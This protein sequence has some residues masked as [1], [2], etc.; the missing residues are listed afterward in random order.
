MN[1]IPRNVHLAG[2]RPAASQKRPST[3]TL[4]DS[5]RDHG[6]WTRAA[7]LYRLHLRRK[8]LDFAI[9]VQLGHA[10]KEFGSHVEALQAY[11]K[12]FNINEN[13]LDLLL[14]L[15]H[16]YKQMGLA[17][18]A[19]EHYRK[20]ARIDQNQH[21]RAELAVLSSD[22]QRE[23]HI[24][25]RP[26][27]S[28]GASS[29]VSAAFEQWLESLGRM[30][31]RPLLRRANQARD[32]HNWN[33][34]A[35]DYQRYLRRN[36]NAFAIWVQ[37][38]HALRSSGRGDEALAAY[39]RALA[40]DGENAD[41][42]LNIGH[43]YKVT[44]RPATALTYYQRSAEIDLNLHAASEARALQSAGHLSDATPTA[45]GKLP[46]R[47]SIHEGLVGSLDFVNSNIAAG[48]AWNPQHPDAPAIVEFL[49]D[50][51]VIHQ[52][53]AKLYREDVKSLGYG[54]GYAG[55]HTV[56]PI[57]L[58][59]DRP[60]LHARLA[61]TNAALNNSPVVLER[62]AN[63]TRW[64]RRTTS[65]SE[66]FYSRLKKRVDRETSGVISIVMPVY[67]TDPAWLREAIDS[68][69]NQWC[70]RWELICVDDASTAPHVRAILEEYSARDQRIKPVY[71]EV[72]AGIATST[73][74]GIR[75]S[76]G[77]LIAFMDHDDYIEPDAVYKY[78]SA[79]RKTHADLLYCDELITTDNLNVVIAAA[80]RPA[81]SWDY[82]LSHPYFVHMI[83]VSRSLIEAVDGWDQTMVISAD[84]DFVLRCTEKA[85]TVTH[86]PSVLYRWRTHTQSAGHQ[87]M[88]K[89]TGATLGA[90]NKH[91]SR[92]SPGATAEEGHG[93]NR[94]RINFPDDRGKV[95]CCYSNQERCAPAAPLHEPLLATTTPRELDIIVI[96]HGV[97]R[98][99]DDSLYGN[100]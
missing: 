99:R 38:G 97:R 81:F 82:Y 79:Y 1:D 71:S 18:I 68:V 56:L 84:V 88:R 20:S 39:S 64:L 57:E 45:A 51:K 34:A 42:L 27:T 48:W 5:A 60:T 62:P 29:T 16:L 91:L 32:L 47:P 85:G 43:L 19:I 26:A 73:N 55:F 7:E 66:D 53:T 67:N 15:G 2:S 25:S 13:D 76:T 70:S 54:N 30:M 87:Q 23:Q 63:I 59:D 41:L 89:V 69:L 86:I 17:D 9:W 10:L 75:S 52:T 44:G 78:L 24:S 35:T 33:A 36:P 95:L 4:A 93:F 8:P 46:D 28:S 80:A 22:E 98:P 83:C 58:G 21:A 65:K 100:D 50:G 11:S 61:G 49:I 37:L 90:L 92:V 94:Y 3:R 77:S 74:L 96:D 40:L 72:N 14:N 12:A 31:A 6:D